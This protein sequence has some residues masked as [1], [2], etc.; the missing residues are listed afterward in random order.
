MILFKVKEFQFKYLTGSL[1][2]IYLYG[3]AFI[4]NYITNAILYSV[5]V[6][7]ISKRLNK[8]YAALT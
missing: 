6:T 4:H 7:P 1:Q 2:P 5:R 8:G 3:I